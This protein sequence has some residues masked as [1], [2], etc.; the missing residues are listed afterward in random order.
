MDHPLP[1]SLAESF[2]CLRL[3]FPPASPVGSIGRLANQFYFVTSDATAKE[4]VE[5]LKNLSDVWAIGVVNRK[6]EGLGI[7]TVS[8]FQAKMSLPFAYDVRQNHP[9]ITLW[10]RRGAGLLSGVVGLTRGQS[11]K[12]DS[13]LKAHELYRH[14]KAESACDPCHKGSACGLVPKR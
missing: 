12:R 2:R 10:Y 13:R 4:L 8:Q 1:A 14:A 7:I 9:K 11:L 5:D 3:S 6:G